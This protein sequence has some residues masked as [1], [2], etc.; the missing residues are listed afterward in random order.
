MDLKLGYKLKL[1]G[2]ERG[3]REV[4]HWLQKWFESVSDQDF[5]A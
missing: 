5:H 2:R 1:F 4:N 3:M